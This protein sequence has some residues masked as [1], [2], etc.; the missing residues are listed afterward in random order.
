MNNDALGWVLFCAGTV[1]FV[2]FCARIIPQTKGR[3][4]QYTIRPCICGRKAPSITLY[5]GGTGGGIGGFLVLYIL[6]AVAPSLIVVN[7]STLNFAVI[8]RDGWVLS[9]MLIIA[10]A[11]GLVPFFKHIRSGHSLACSARRGL[12]GIAWFAHSKH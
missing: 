4:S 6:L 8:S 10:I 3:N 5:L 11:P 1:G 12:L 9:L 2:I 7:A